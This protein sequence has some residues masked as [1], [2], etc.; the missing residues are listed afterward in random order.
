MKSLHRFAFASLA[1]SV[2]GL[3]LLPLGQAS[4]VA[5]EPPDPKS[6]QRDD[7]RGDIVA[8]VGLM[9][10]IACRKSAGKPSVHDGSTLRIN[11]S[12]AT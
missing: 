10:S 5:T 8:Q 3:S 1:S 12:V 7:R 11:P 4:G 6:P 2:V 9:R